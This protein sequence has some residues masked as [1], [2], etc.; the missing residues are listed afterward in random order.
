V[1]IANERL[2]RIQPEMSTAFLALLAQLP[3]AIREMPAD[4][5]VMDLARRFQLS[6]YD[7]VYLDLAIRERVPLA[8]LDEGLQTAARALQIRHWVPPSSG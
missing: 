2:G 3:V 6:V 5:G 8:S 7:A 4:T 1:L